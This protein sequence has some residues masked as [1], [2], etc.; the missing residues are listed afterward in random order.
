MPTGERDLTIS[1]LLVGLLLK[2]AGQPSSRSSSRAI[3]TRWI[4]FV[5]S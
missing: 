5:P 2:W 1:G 3:T 4:W